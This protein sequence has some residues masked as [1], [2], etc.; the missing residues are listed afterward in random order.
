MGA[1]LTGL[2]RWGQQAGQTMATMLKPSTYL[3]ILS[4]EI[5]LADLEADR[6]ESQ[7]SAVSIQINWVLA[8]PF[9]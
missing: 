7:D 6:A 4:V 9:N 8:I 5:R 3:R 2:A 1:V